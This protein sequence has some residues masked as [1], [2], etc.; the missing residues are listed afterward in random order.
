MKLHAETPQNLFIIVQGHGVKENP[1]TQ[2]F[3][4]IWRKTL[5]ERQAD[6]SSILTIQVSFLISAAADFP[7][8][9]LSTGMS[10]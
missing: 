7:N 9:G 3:N 1:V 10:L 2:E 4:K 6:I 5:A 8:T